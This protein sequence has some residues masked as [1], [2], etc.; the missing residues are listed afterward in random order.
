MKNNKPDKI[1]FSGN[2]F[3][4]IELLIS[5]SLFVILISISV[6]IFLKTIR[7]QKTALMLID[8]GNNLSLSVEEMAREMRQGINFSGPENIFGDYIEFTDA[9]TGKRIRY[10]INNG[11]LIE[12]VDGVPQQLTSEGVKVTDFEVQLINNPNFPPRV[13]LNMSVAPN[14]DL[15]Q[16]Y[17]TQIQTTIS[18]RLI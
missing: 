16:N 5:I 2:G 6:S 3:S 15:L 4:I 10:E 17:K 9:A 11:A 7:T 13:F 14:S 18:S 8:A 1:K 12:R